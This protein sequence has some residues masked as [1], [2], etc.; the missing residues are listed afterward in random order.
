[1]LLALAVRAAY[2][3]DYRSSPLWATPA[4][5]DV[6]EY[7]EWAQTILS[8]RWLWDHVPIHAPLYAYWLAGCYALSGSAAWIARAAQL[9]LGVGAMAL[10]MHVIYRSA[11]R[12]AGLACGLL[13]AVYV[14]LIY[15]EA[16][17]LS[18]GLLLL[19]NCAAIA[20]CAACRGPMTLRRAAAIG[21][22]LGLSIL[23]HAGNLLFALLL[24]GWIACR[25]TGA[26]TRRS[27]APALAATAAAA[28]LIAPVAIHNSRIAGEFVLVQKHGGL[29]FFIGNNPAADGTPNI[30]FGPAW[31]RLTARPH[32]EAG[33]FRTAGRD[34]FF[35]DRAL[36]FIRE[37][38][39]AWLRLLGQ[40]L[41]LSL[42]AEEIPASAPLEALKPDVWLLRTGDRRFG[43][44][45][46]LA[47]VGLATGAR[48][49]PPPLLLLTL[50]VVV[51]Q[52]IGVASGRYRVPML[53][54]VLALAGV[55]FAE[56]LGAARANWR[57]ALRRMLIPAAIAILVSFL[58]SQARS[59]S[60]AAEGAMARGQ[61]WR[62]KGDW[63]AALSE[64][65]NAVALQPSY[66]AG[67][68]WL[69]YAA[70]RLGLS[71]EQLDH[72]RQAVAIDPA[73]AWAELVLGHA[74]QS[75]GRLAESL[76]RYRRA[77][78]IDPEYHD[79]RV[80]LAAALRLADR[81]AEALSEFRRVLSREQRADAR[82]G[83]I[84]AERRLDGLLLEA[85]TAHREQRD[86]DALSAV[87]PVLAAYPDSREAL[88]LAALL[89]AASA[90]PR[91]HDAGEALRLARRA[92]A[93]TAGED[94]EALDVL[95][96]AHARGGD[97][98]AAAA[99]ARRAAR[100]AETRGEM[101]LLADIVSRIGLYERGRPFS[102]TAATEAEFPETSPRPR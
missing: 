97:F 76:D 91:V 58:P 102:L 89:R 39:L 21:L 57:F 19:L 86:C 31:D 77:L 74:L 26:T 73:Y 59:Y 98:E 16:E 18:E 12:A 61:A 44:L 7:H 100:R 49:V 56:I 50:A 88:L 95:A 67:H 2:L 78:E 63:N 96:M 46:A 66:A 11:G 37:R 38:P 45:L 87:T 41:L 14:P 13:W 35:T 5:P 32:V 28:L 30:R 20:A 68:V 64:F 80:A 72:L 29:N 90:D 85:Q 40:K 81:P 51:T 15:Y 34:R 23:T 47:A 3:L 75:R 17:L 33:L 4:G 82:A 10:I 93:A 62:L 69:A 36:E 9:L 83:L 71:D 43:L 22:I 27:V 53:P 52:V 65:R 70:G 79:A 48:R 55:G 25:K 92:A 60:F 54:G 6:R 99:V 42:S 1:M 24:I 101:D 8:G 94:A 84:D